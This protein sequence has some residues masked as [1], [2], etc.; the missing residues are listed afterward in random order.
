M[1][2][3]GQDSVGVLGTET[4]LPDLAASTCVCSATSPILSLCLLNRCSKHSNYKE[5]AT[6]LQ[7]TYLFVTQTSL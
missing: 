3:C 5:N 1:C 2:I 7:N 4:R 6:K